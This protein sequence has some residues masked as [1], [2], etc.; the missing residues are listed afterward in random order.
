MGGFRRCQRGHTAHT[1]K[2]PRKARDKT[3]EK[4]IQAQGE[5]YLRLKRL[6]FI[7]IPDALNRSIFANPEIPIWTKKHI[8]DFIKGLPD[9]TILKDG[10]YLAVELKKDGGRLTHEQ[11]AIRRE[12][13]GIVCY[14]F[15]EFK[16][17]LEAWLK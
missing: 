15:E 7:R 10:R 6:F 12:I 11:D 16:T 13:G 5:A 3:P 4:V 9:L 1:A 17:A 8:S 2:A 14:N